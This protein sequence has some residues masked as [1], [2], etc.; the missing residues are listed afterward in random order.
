MRTPGRAGHRRAD[1]RGD[2]AVDPG[3]DRPGDPGGGAAPD[4]CSRGR[5]GPGDRPGLRDDRGDRPGHPAPGASTVATYWFCCHRVPGRL[6]GGGELRR[7]VFVTGLVL[8][9]GTSSRLGAPKQ[10]LPYRGRTLLD[11]TL[12]DRPRLRVRPAA[13]DPR[14]L[15]RRRSASRSTWPV[16]EVVENPDF[17]TGCSSSIVTALDA[18]DAAADGLV[19]L[20]GDQ[21]GVTAGAVRALVATAADAPL[22]VCRYDDGPG[23]PFWFGRAVF[24]ELRGLHGDKARVE[25]ARVRAAPRRTGRGAWSGAAGR[26]RPGRTTKRCWRRTPGRRR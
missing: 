11:A 23:H 7:G 25:A 3:R 26:G 20:L 17:G 12:R 8:A 5:A 18:V 2:R 14:G 24:G 13:G 22:G 1:R 21:P 10:L 16:C 9:A 19:L 15:P 6:R 4:R